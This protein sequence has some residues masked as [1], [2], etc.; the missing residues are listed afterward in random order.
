MYGYSGG[1]R[2]D[3][4]HI[5]NNISFNA[6]ACVERFYP[7]YLIGGDTPIT[8]VIYQGNVGYYT[9]TYLSG[10]YR[11]GHGNA[12]IGG[13]QVYDNYF[14]TNPSTGDPSMTFRGSS[15]DIVRFDGNTLIGDLPEEGININDW[16]NNTYLSSL[17]TSGVFYTIRQ[18][19]YKTTRYHVA[20]FNWARLNSVT[21][22]TNLQR[23]QN[24]TITNVQD[25]ANDIV[26]GVIGAN[27]NLTI[28][29]IN[30]TVAT[31]YSWTPPPSTFPKFGAFMIDMV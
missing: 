29:M 28:S 20:I 12:A 4:F 30:H 25:W 21:I 6:G 9:P 7:N 13:I 8:S 23:G 2:I 10:G 19:S 22:S 16:P 17:P 1:S 24:V 31:P 14:V 5:K 15:V 3:N 27:G 26:N 11:I 18:N